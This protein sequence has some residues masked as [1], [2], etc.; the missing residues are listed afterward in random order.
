MDNVGDSLPSAH[1]LVAACSQ[2][3]TS[4]HAPAP[5]CT[6]PHSF[7]LPLPQLILHSGFSHEELACF[8]EHLD[9][10]LLS[11]GAD[12]SKD[13]QGWE[14]GGQA[15]AAVLPQRVWH[16]DGDAVL[17]IAGRGEHL[18]VSLSGDL[19]GHPAGLEPQGVGGEDGCDIFLSILG[20]HTGIE[21]YTY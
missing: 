19:V 21:K 13:S 2:A 18:D 10:V 15:D 11:G 12:V 20:K 5:S 8:W 1:R 9:S 14:H 16:L 6:V 4:A 17:V 7:T 3:R